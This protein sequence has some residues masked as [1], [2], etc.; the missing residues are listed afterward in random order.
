MSALATAG[1]AGIEEVT[2][3]YRT[4]TTADV[5]VAF[6]DGHSESFAYDLVTNELTAVGGS[7]AAARAVLDERRRRA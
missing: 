2:L 7:G 5:D 6:E 1:L 4:S 3:G